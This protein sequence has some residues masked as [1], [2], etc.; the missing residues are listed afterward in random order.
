MSEEMV[1]V[2]GVQAVKYSTLAVFSLVR[3]VDFF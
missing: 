1:D 2:Q 3:I